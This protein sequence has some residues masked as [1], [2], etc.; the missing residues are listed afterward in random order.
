MNSFQFIGHKLL[1]KTLRLGLAFVLL[2][3]GTLSSPA[4][5]FTNLWAYAGAAYKQKNWEQTIDYCNK[6]IELETNNPFGYLTR[7]G[8]FV[9]TKQFEKAESDFNRA[10][11][12]ATD[13][14]LLSQ[15]YLMRGYYY[16]QITNF[17]KA[18]NDYSKAIQINPA[19]QMAYVSRA[20]AYKLQHRYD[21]SILD[22]NMATMLNP[23]DVE[24]NFYKGEAFSGKHEYT[25][26][27]EAYSKAIAIDTNYCWAYYQ[28]AVAYCDRDD[29]PHAIKDFDKLIQLQPTN[30]EAYSARGLAK[31]KAGDFGAAIEDCRKGVQLDTNST[32]ALNNLAWLLATAPK[33]KRRDGQ[34]AV[35]YATRACE[36]D[37]WKNPYY[38]GTLA[39]A[40]AEVGNFDE[41]IKWERKCIII[42]LPDKEMEQARRELKLFGNRQPFHADK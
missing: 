32:G 35:E 23:D 11:V 19:F 38:L 42:G 25:K 34:K 39:A 37:L 6:A 24:A 12:L 22:C 26:A 18:V 13:A 3:L 36:L 15:A 29:Y 30:A 33:S 10:I 17:D 7:G 28:R 20:H 8:A 31:S 40:N 21:L 16:S 5:N 9:N 1:V 27:I 2:L 4:E 41:A 14:I